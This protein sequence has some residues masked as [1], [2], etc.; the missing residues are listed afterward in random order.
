MDGATKIE[1]EDQ[2]AEEALDRI[3]ADYKLEM[4]LNE[5][6]KELKQPP[7]EKKGWFTRFK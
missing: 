4:G 3:N 5:V 1:G 2:R 7:V 6:R